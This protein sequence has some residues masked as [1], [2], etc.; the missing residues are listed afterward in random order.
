M[1]GD[2]RGKRPAMVTIRERGAERQI[3]LYG[4]GEEPPASH[5]SQLAIY[6]AL[7]KPLYP[8]RQ[9][10][11]ALVYVSGPVLIEIP[12]PSLEVAIS[13]LAG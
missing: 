7:L 1:N 8:G 6:R 9:I 5:V 10:D 11:A 13:G 12:G 3:P 4:P 2:M